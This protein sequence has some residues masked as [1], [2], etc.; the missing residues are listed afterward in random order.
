VDEAHERSLNIDF[1]L[2]IL[3]TLLVR[4]RNLKIVITS[5]TIDTEKFSRAFNDAPIIVVSGR[6]Y[7]VEVRYAPVDP[8]LEEGGDWT[9]IDAAVQAADELREER[10]HGDI[11]IFMPSEA[12]IRE[13]CDLLTARSEPGDV[14]LPLFARLTGDEQRRVFQSASGRKIVVATNVAETSVTIPGIRYVIDAGLARI[15]RYNPRTRT[16]NLPIAPVSRSSA[17]QRKGR[18]GRT[19]NGVCIRLYSREDYD[20]RPLYTPPE[21]IRSNLAE[22]ILRMLALNIGDAATFPFID[23]PDSK[24]IRDGYEMLQELGAVVP[25]EKGRGFQLTEQ[26]RLMA[27]MPVDPRISR[28]LLEAEKEGCVREVAVI[29]AAL[30]IQD[31]RE[32]PAEK[33]EEARHAQEL[34][35]HPASDFLTLLNIWDRYREA[36]DVYKTQNRLRRFCREHFLS[37][38]RMREWADLH[39]QVLEVL[40]ELGMGKAD[41]RE[42]SDYQLLYGGIH[43]SILAGYLSNI[44]VKKEKNFYNAAR[45]REA[46]L[47]PGSG[48]FNRGSDW[49]V[50]A[51]MVET[52]RLFARTAAHIESD[53]IESLGGDLCRNT[54]S[55]PHWERKRGEVTASEQVSLYGLVIVAARS[56]SYGPINPKEAAKI[57]ICQALVEGDV[58]RPLPFLRHNLD[59]AEKVSGIEDKLRRRDLLASEEAMMDF[60]EK[61]LCGVYD[62]RTLQ[63]RI[64]EKGR[65][66]FL[67]MSEEDLLQYRLEESDLALYPDNL[68]L[69]K[70]NFQLLYRFAPQQA[71]D[72][73]TIEVPQRLA[74]YVPAPATDWLV[75]GLLAEKITLLLKG[76]PKGYRKQ[77][78]PLAGTVE[79][80]VNEMPRAEGS[81]LSTLS[82]FIHQRFE[83]D[84]PASAWNPDGLPDYLKM[85]FAVTDA[86]GR[87]LA[88]GRDLHVLQETVVEDLDAQVF[89]KMRARFERKGITRWDFGDLPEIL[90]IGEKGH[91]AFAFP[92][93]GKDAD[94]AA[95]NLRLFRSAREA[96]LSHRQG[97]IALFAMRFPKELKAL[98]SNL[99]LSK[100]MKTAA[101]YFGG[102]KAVE[103][104]IFERTLRHLF[105]VSVRSESEFLDHAKAA[106]SRVLPMG[107]KMLQEVQPVVVAYHNTRSALREMDEANRSN[108]AARSFLHAMHGELDRLVPRDFLVSVDNERLRQLPRY[109][110]ALVVRA[111]SGL[112]HLE[113]DHEKSKKVEIFATALEK[114]QKD[115][116]VFSSTDKVKTVAEFGRMIEEYRISVFAQKVKTA[117]PVSPKR[118]EA[119]LREI[120]RMI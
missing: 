61:R 109:L 23:P 112:L 114:L 74:S 53:W 57:F 30:S 44:A 111:E 90:P 63:K 17:D 89:E 2:G 15:S 101:V 113:K 34:F 58:E 78:L 21:I 39:G 86:K 54:Y 49:I 67:R 118:L 77:L 26:G 1:I 10:R 40:R 66:D 65:D 83:V 84:I 85:R 32:W 55:N 88:S 62:I 47:F 100:E 110:E 108:H 45:G 12:D 27:R 56:V 5:A 73:V 50:A 29:A 20:N 117:I 36:W 4:R 107:Q 72:G 106:A 96:Q 35:R 91:Q 76:L 115:L 18:C 52:T 46:M 87:E 120:E 25:K 38:R 24:S 104:A 11:L 8:E 59:L 79:T 6:L 94:E 69:G 95:V 82:A 19:A 3:K 68:A 60:Y 116:T 43:R 16:L 93:L 9:Y 37:Y 33:L 31:P 102:E 80:I 51:E 42:K 71:D 48:L 7:P 13:T 103:N 75:P 92:A 70:W 22:V 81:L 64:R 99:S 41:L 28:M 119:K 105:D 97:V 14:V 98:R